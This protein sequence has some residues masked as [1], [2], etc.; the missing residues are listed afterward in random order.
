MISYLIVDDEYPIREWLVF[1]IKQNC[2]DVL[3]ESADN[4]AEA[5]I[6]LQSKQYDFLFTDI[7][8]PKLNGLELLQSVQTISPSTKV[9]VL[10]SYDDYNYVRHAFK[11]FALDYL[12]K[13]E[14]TEDQ[15]VQMITQQQNLLKNTNT[16]QDIQNLIIKYIN[17]EAMSFADFDQELRRYG[18]TLPES[19]FFCY[20]IKASGS[21]S[22][23]DMMIRIP[24]IKN[25]ECV[26]FCNL[27]EQ[28]Q[29]GIIHMK[30]K[31]RLMQLQE[32][33]LF[34]NELKQ[35]NTYSLILASDIYRTKP[36]HLKILR[37]TAAYRDTEFYGISFHAITEAS[38]SW[39]VSFDQEYL[40]ILKNI[41]FQNWEDIKG[42]L[43]QFLNYIGSVRYPD[44]KRLKDS[45]EKLYEISYVYKTPKH[46]RR[47]SEKLRD[48]SSKIAGAPQFMDL[49]RIALAEFEALYSTPTKT[50]LSPNILCCI[51]YIESHYMQEISLNDLANHVHL[52][53][54]YLSRH[55][56]KQTGSNFSSYL[57]SYRLSKAAILIKDTNEKISEISLQVGFNNFAYFSKCFKDIYGCSP[58]EWRNQ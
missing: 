17:N 58:M 37:L 40:K 45:L 23:E 18:V 1:T 56:K 3:V 14:I 35:F 12:L 33:N 9:I 10:S 39:N 22:S 7:R 30:Q 15:L 34:F 41:K 50:M 6:K 19:D 53:P 49:Q 16:K 28:S 46:D 26:L 42:S 4:G 24:S 38:S 8:M 43:L 51:D 52:N 20:F 27:S 13:A 57:T 29:L 25:T 47:Y 48:A 31:S 2:P 21:V 5:L 36:G 54:E 55:F 11:H 44:I 32:R